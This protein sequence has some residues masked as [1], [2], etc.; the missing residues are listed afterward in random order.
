MSD[1][2]TGLR[3]ILMLVENLSYPEDPRVRS[4]ARALV[5]ASFHVSVVAPARQGKR[6]KE[7]LEGVRVY[8]Y[9][10]PPTG[11][12]FLGYLWEYLYSLT[13]IFFL[14]LVVW[15]SEGIDVIH[16]ANPPDV[17]VLVAFPFKLLGKRFVF[18]HHDLAPEMY[19]AVFGDQAKPW[20]YQIQVQFEILS[21]GLADQVIATN[22]SYRAV[23]MTRGGIP[24]D[25]ITVVRNGPD[26]DRLHIVAPDAE[27]RRKAR[28][29]I[30]YVGVMGI[31]DRVDSLLWA[32]SYLR[33]DLRRKDFFCVLVGSGDMCDHLK[34]LGV[35]LGVD[36]HVWFTGR[37]PDED[38]VRYLSTTDI[39]V[40][41][42]NA[43]AFTDRS[44]MVKLMEYMALGKPVVAFDLTEHRYTAQDAAIYVAHN[45]AYEL[46]KAIAALM[47]DPA[48]RQAMG[49]RGRERIERELAWQYSVP[50]LLQVYMRLFANSTAPRSPHH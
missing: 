45:D 19:L 24:E 4:E 37:V 21:C 10:P 23:E 3:K 29:I 17:L 9:P 16:A 2:K 14:S 39:C 22:Q 7:T 6:W 20:V 33:Y 34:R 13:T 47:D 25:R 50:R 8:R 11:R 38:L 5:D 27:L 44:T 40:V 26:L 15:V 43:N 28:I 31:H 46:A 49:A 48:R 41:P 32:L 35:E 42:D 18:D 1:S 30:G 36:S 12:G